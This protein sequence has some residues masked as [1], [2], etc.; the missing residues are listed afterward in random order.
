MMYQRKAGAD[1]GTQ[2]H[3]QRGVIVVA[4]LHQ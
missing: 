1:V 3:D 4:M 2:V